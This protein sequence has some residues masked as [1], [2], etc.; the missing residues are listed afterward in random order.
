MLP[1][2]ISRYLHSIGLFKKYPRIYH[3]EKPTYD[4]LEKAVETVFSIHNMAK[5]DGDIQVFLTSNNEIRQFVQK[6]DNFKQIH[7]V[8]GDQVF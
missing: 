8:Q 2:V 1:P 5:I 6:F 3:L 7:K 4:Y